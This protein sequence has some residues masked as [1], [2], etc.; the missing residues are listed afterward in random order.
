VSTVDVSTSFEVERGQSTVST[1]DCSNVQLMGAAA[2]VAAQHEC[3]RPASGSD[4]ENGDFNTAFEEVVRLRHT[5]ATALAVES[6]G[7]LAA[8]AQKTKCPRSPTLSAVARAVPER[9]TE[10]RSRATPKHGGRHHH[11][12][13]LR[14]KKREL[15]REKTAQR[16]DSIAK[17]CVEGAS[18]TPSSASPAAPALDDTLEALTRRIGLGT[19]HSAELRLLGADTVEHLCWLQEDDL[20]SSFAPL[21]V[22]RLMGEV[23]RL[24]AARAL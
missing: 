11:H 23:E 17:D 16:D 10:V 14:R 9:W 5:I 13:A 4:I 15:H 7:A 1:V 19:E 22:R 18:S 24:R 3:E 8:A 20:T 21:H 6:P 2:L 12:S